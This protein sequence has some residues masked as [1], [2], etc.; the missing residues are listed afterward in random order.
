MIIFSHFHMLSTPDAA[1]TPPPSFH[2]FRLLLSTAAIFDAAFH[3][4][5]RQAADFQP[6]AA[7]AFA[8]FRLSPSLASPTCR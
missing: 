7:M 8:A 1:F 2:E 3:A 5:F 6:F 4:G